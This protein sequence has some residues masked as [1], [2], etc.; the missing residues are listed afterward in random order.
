[1]VLSPAD[2]DFWMGTYTPLDP[3]AGPSA[4]A[5]RALPCGYN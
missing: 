4:P 3:W 5:V 1:M 2:R